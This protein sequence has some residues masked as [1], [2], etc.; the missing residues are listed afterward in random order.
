[1]CE[2]SYDD[3]ASVHV[4]I[5]IRLYLWQI[6]VAWLLLTCRQVILLCCFFQCCYWGPPQPMNHRD[7]TNPA[8]PVSDACV[9]DTSILR[10]SDT[11]SILPLCYFSNPRIAVSLYS[12]RVSVI[13]RPQQCLIFQKN[14]LMRLLMH[15]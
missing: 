10:Y 2:C 6:Y 13:H 14:N 3:C 12:Y 5:H 11:L 9:S 15:I 1:V 8:V 4:S 7:F